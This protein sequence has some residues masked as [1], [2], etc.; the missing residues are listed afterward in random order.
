[1]IVEPLWRLKRKYLRFNPSEHSI[2]EVCGLN[3]KFIPY[4]RKYG[5]LTQEQLKTL[6]QAAKYQKWQALD[7]TNCGLSE[8]PDELWELPDLQI[9][10]LGNRSLRGS[11]TEKSIVLDDAEEYIPLN[12]T[13]STL[14]RG[15]E[16]LENLQVLSIEY[17]RL[18]DTGDPPLVMKRLIYLDAFNC[19][20]SQLPRVLQIPSL[21]Q[22]GFTCQEEHLA[23]DFLSMPSLTHLYLTRSNILSLPENIGVLKNLKT[24]YLAGTKIVSLPESLETVR[25][26]EHLGLDHTPL[27][28]SIPP[29][30]LNQSAKEI[31][32]YVLQQQSNVPKQ[33]FN[34]S[35]M[36]IV[37][38]GHVGKTCVLNRLINNTYSE[39]VS[40]EGIDISSWRFSFKRQSYKLNV[41]DF[42]GQEIYHSTHQFFLTE[43]SLYL[44]V[45]DALAEEEYGRIDYWLKTIQSFA[46]GSPVIIVVNKCDHGIGRIR[47]IDEDDYCARFPQIKKI[48]YVSCKDDIQ[49]GALRNYIKA[50]AVKLPLMQTTWI[51]SW[52]TIRQRLE[53]L[54]VEKNFISYQ[55]YLDLCAAEQIGEDEALSLAKYLHDLGI[56]LYYHDDPLLKD[57]V[58]L[59]S[60]WGTDAVYKILDEQERLLKGRNGILFFGDLPRIWNDKERYPARLY[61]YL[62]NLMEKF[63]LAFKFGSAEPAYLVAE[64]LDNKAIDLNWEFPFGVTLCFRYEYDFLPAG[65]MTRFIV[66]I[67]TYLETIDGMKQCWRKG[68]YLRH[69]TAY[70]LVR[71][72][73]SITDRYIQ[74][75]VSGRQ[76][77]DRQEL[78]TIIRL[79]FD[80]MNSQFNQI[81]ITKRIPCICSENCDFLFDYE[82]LLKAE[83]LGKQTIECHS[84]LK[85]VSLKKMLDGVDSTMDSQYGPIVIH[86]MPNF[87]NNTNVSVSAHSTTCVEVT[88]EVRGWICDMQGDLNDL[89]SEIGTESGELNDQLQKIADALEKL[90]SSQSKEEIRKSGMMNRIRRFLEECHNPESQTGKI[91]KGVKYAGQIVKELAGKYNKVAKWAALPPLPFG[92]N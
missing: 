63:Q 57:L 50:Q 14:P 33:F 56:V 77:R 65:V 46:G 43:R 91:L 11:N 10:Y 2:A 9:L 78:L 75:S 84:S 79:F 74:I 85:A 59:S 42:G 55:E 51:S 69:K 24:L 4:Y 22:I 44:L 88:A 45:W 7:L 15:F 40:T 30:I 28:K 67:N 58:I 25:S 49:I 86:N 61:P 32:R 12:N 19:G 47:R 34:E 39:K 21:Q 80:E 90:E 83:L 35:K 1:M 36:V 26:L 52:M 48:F 72:Y 60:E 76:P 17:N 73:D 27:A 70:A 8:L 81:K 37:G 64:L 54:S 66:A 41:W 92:G 82:T 38:Q 13:F 53:E 29:E 18:Q 6:I 20:F 23:I 3:N 71:L 89:K 68:A 87:S 5:A 62:L 31:V 16:R